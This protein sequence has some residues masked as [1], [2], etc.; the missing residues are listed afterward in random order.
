MPSVSPS[1]KAMT[2]PLVT[3]LIKTYSYGRFIEQAT[4]SVLSQ[5][6]QID[7]VQILVADR[8]AARVEP[9]C[10]DL[11]AVVEHLASRPFLPI[12]RYTGFSHI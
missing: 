10:A 3:V 5:D 11:L 4:D 6:F 9:R 7:Q 12:F 2:T 1:S 8:E